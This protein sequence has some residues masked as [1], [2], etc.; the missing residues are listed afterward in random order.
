VL[1]DGHACEDRGV[2]GGVGDVGEHNASRVYYKGVILTPQNY[3]NVPFIRQ[4]FTSRSPPFQCTPQC[5]KSILSR[6]LF[7]RTCLGNCQD[8]LQIHFVSNSSPKNTGKTSPQATTWINRKWLTLST[9]IS[10]MTQ[11]WQ[12]KSANLTNLANK[13]L[14]FAADYLSNNQIILLL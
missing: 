6:I 4:L 2:V 8:V 1:Q 5:R 11:K 7:S 3:K 9:R 14:I 12:P 10:R 13:F